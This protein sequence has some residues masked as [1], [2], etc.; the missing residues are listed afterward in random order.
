MNRFAIPD[1]NLYLTLLLV[2]KSSVMRD[3]DLKHPRKSNCLTIT[4]HL[5]PRFGGIATSL[6]LLCKAIEI[7]GRYGSSLAAF[8]DSSE[9]PHLEPTLDYRQFS[10]SRIDWILNRRLR[11]DFDQYAQPASL[12]HIHGIWETHCAFASRWARSNKRPYLI[13]AHGMLDPW[14]LRQK[15]WKKKL[16]S[17]IIEK[18]NLQQADCLRAITLSE[19]AQYR[20]FGLTNPIAIIPNGVNI[21]EHLSPEFFWQQY[22]KLREK[23][24]V[25]FLGRLHPKK[26]II[27]LCRAWP[28]IRSEF[29]E[30]HL[31]FAGPD[32]EGSEALLLETISSHKLQD[33]VSLIGPI[34]GDL[35]W[36][37]Y[38]AATIF[39]LPSFSEGFSI[40]VLESMGA[41][42]PVVISESC[43]F[44]EAVKAGA[45]W[46]TGTS[47]DEIASAVIT[48]LGTGLSARNS[49]GRLAAKLI[50]DEYTWTQ[51]AIQLAD[52]QDWLLGGSRPA[53]VQTW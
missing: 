15:R 1:G 10:Q 44:P 16:Y 14:A 12:I 23:S 30:A 27:P 3:V 48:A 34:F 49:M 29:P 26:G 19:A 21:P 20:A 7:D 41:G 32:C 50:K 2:R 38:I 17:S 25:L 22:P 40:A 24:I 8:C 39:V 31:V 33:S 46:F 13:S 45:G 18:Y 37:A 47:E 5:D 6:P 51:I 9:L 36:S 43:Y 4:S 28:Q 52:V 11:A 42:T 35:K 53:S